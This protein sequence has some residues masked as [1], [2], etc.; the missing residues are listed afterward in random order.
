MRSLPPI[1]V[2]AVC[3]V[4]GFVLG[5]TTIVLHTDDLDLPVGFGDLIGSMLGVAGAFGAA[6]YIHIDAERR[7]KARVA[8]VILPTIDNLIRN[9]EVAE[10]MADIASR[11][12]NLFETV[13]LDEVLATVLASIDNCMEDFKM[14]PNERAE[15]IGIRKEIEIQEGN[16][17]FLVKAKKY[18]KDILSFWVGEETVLGEVCTKLATIN[19]R[20][21][22]LHK[23]IGRIS[24]RK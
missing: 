14:L 7:E 11:S 8:A 5:A 4:L 17:R 16:V 9:A 2:M 15:L 20:L 19:S 22:L 23:G 21:K 24:E 3:I 12:P 10:R 6:W 13:D 1:A 18:N